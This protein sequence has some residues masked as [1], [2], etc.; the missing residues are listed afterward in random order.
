MLSRI[1]EHKTAAQKRGNLFKLI[2]AITNTKVT[3]QGLVFV[4]ACLC[5]GMVPLLDIRVNPASNGPAFP[6]WPEHFNGRTLVGMSLSEVER[7]FDAQF[8]GRLAR[9]QAGHQNLVIRWVTR[10]TRKL[11][12]AADC[13]RG[14]GFQLKYLPLETG[15]DGNRWAAFEA[16]KVRTYL[17]RE[18]IVDADGRQWT[19]VSSW[20]W[21]A[22]L[23]KSDGPW[24][25]FTVS[26]VVK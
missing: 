19:D 8:P 11:H 23:G 6:G 4:L 3:L 18:R 24:W 10:P 2:P 5:A 25:A 12:G 9:F 17:V 7:R 26:E 15:G 21:A 13:Y 16:K 14:S 20:Y 22:L 1:D